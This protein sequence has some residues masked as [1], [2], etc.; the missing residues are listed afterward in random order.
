MAI[1]VVLVDKLLSTT[2]GVGVATV[3]EVF[4][5]SLASWKGS[6][7]FGEPR[8]FPFASPGLREIDFA[9]YSGLSSLLDCVVF[10]GGR[11]DTRRTGEEALLVDNSSNTIGDSIGLIA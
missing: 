5:D 2:G 6:R 9:L 11:E 3:F 8:I 7:D 10:V 1:L 4:V